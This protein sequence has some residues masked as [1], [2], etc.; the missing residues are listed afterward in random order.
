MRSGI[1]GREFGNVVP[2]HR[3]S[4]DWLT[5]ESTGT[6]VQIYDHGK[7]KIILTSLNLLPA[8]QRDAL[9]EGLL[10]NLVNYAA[11]G[12]PPKLGAENPDTI[13]GLRFELQ[14][15]NDCLHKYVTSPSTRK[16]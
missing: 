6:T 16:S 14:G 5:S 9:A 1:M 4:T 10:C 11:K 13:E 8:L 3:I 7:G 2:V 15:Y 12:L